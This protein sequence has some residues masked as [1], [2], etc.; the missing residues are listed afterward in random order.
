CYFCHG[1]AGDARTLAS[2]YLTPPPRDFTAAR[3]DRLSREAMIATVRD[4][5]PGTAMQGFAGRLSAAD[6]E[7]VV[8][9][10]RAELM[11]GAGGGTRYHSPANGWDPARD[12]P[13]I[14]FVTGELPLEASADRLGPQEAAGKRL[15]LATCIS[16]H[17][18][19]GAA[20]GPVWD[21]RAVSFP[22]G[23][24]SHRAERADAVTG[25]TPYAR[26]D[27]PPTIPDLGAAE[28]RGEAL[29]QANCAFCHG[30]DGS[31]RNWIGS[32]LQRRPRDLTD[33]GFMAG[34]TRARLAAR[35]REGVP[36]TSMPAWSGV[37]DDSQIRAL[38][39]YIER[40]FHPLKD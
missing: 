14:A 17:D 23:R 20:A 22:R 4:G 38:I 11:E 12:S 19:G 5:S 29:F 10:V 32:F 16:C 13:A 9:Y 24:Y 35:I 18:A 30:A 15:Y 1:F 25:A 37:L 40:A 27:R 34:M 6:I 28:R 26:H 33:S 7:A 39:A 31:G 8:D 36:G 3:R 2:R 21:T